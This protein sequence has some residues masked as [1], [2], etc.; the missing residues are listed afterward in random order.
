MEIKFTL[1]GKAV[2]CEGEP[3]DT[4]LDVLRYLGCYSLKRACYTGECGNCAII[5]DG[6]LLP[7]CVMPAPQAEGHGLIANRSTLPDSTGFY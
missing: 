6:V 2:T 7:S 3:S 4:L 5:M 1:N